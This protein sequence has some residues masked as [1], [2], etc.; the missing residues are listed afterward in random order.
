MTETL[1]EVDCDLCGSAEKIL[2]KTEEN[3]PISRCRNCSLIYVNRIPNIE[4]GKVIGE[5][6]EGTK[7]EIE[8]SEWRY[9]DVSKYL[10]AEINSFHKEKGALLDVGCGYGFFLLEAKRNG[11]QV[12]GTELSHIAVNYAREKQN[13]P[14]V[15]FS[16]LSDIEF[17]VDKFDAINLTNV[18]EHVPSPTVILDNCASKLAT[19]GVLLI[20]VP[21]MDF[22]NLKEK[23]SSIIKFLGLGKGGE[24]TYLAT[25]PPLHL[26]GYTSRTMEKYFAKAGLETVE[27]KP[28]ELSAMA[29]RSVVFRIFDAVVKILYKI[30]FRRIN[31]SPTILAIAVKR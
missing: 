16:D 2:I 24:L 5:Y 6:Y 19:G 18:L 28:S 11:W 21:N 10:V 1:K 20:R 23:F 4:E 22:H 15:Y 7:A 14:D 17:S 30:S 27:I 9:K 3:Y 29:K 25:R 8:A 12:F 31:I 26:I 13:L